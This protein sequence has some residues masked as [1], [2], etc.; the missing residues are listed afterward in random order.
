MFLFLVFSVTMPLRHNE[1]Q[2]KHFQITLKYKLNIP[3]IHSIYLFTII[4]KLII[5]VFLVL[6]FLYFDIVPQSSTIYMRMRLPRLYVTFT[7]VRQNHGFLNNRENTSIH[8]NATTTGMTTIRI[9]VC[10]PLGFTLIT[11]CIHMNSLESRLLSFLPVM[12]AEKV[13]SPVQ[14][15]PVWS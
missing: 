1:P 12:H 2:W 11:M 7:P 14:N 8:M 4:L 10:S 6:C 3:K 9:I 5:I 15:S 13:K